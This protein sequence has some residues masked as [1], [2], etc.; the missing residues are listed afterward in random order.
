MRTYTT[1]P[2]CRGQTLVVDLTKHR[3]ALKT[4]AIYAARRGDYEKSDQFWQQVDAVDARIAA[5]EEWEV[6]F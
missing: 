5:G 4:S 1:P 2:S 3:E 6:F